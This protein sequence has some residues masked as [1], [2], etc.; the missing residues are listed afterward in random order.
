MK[1][2]LLILLF[3]LPVC[4]AFSQSM[5][6]HAKMTVRSTLKRYIKS[7]DFR[8]SAIAEHGDTMMLQVNEPSV[9]QVEFRY[10]FNDGNWC[11][12]EQKTTCCEKCLSDL[13]TDVLDSKK[14][15][16]IKVNDNTYVSKFSKKR[17]LKI[18]Q[19]NEV[20]QMNITKIKWSKEEYEQLLAA[21]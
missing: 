6:G 3:L 15:E 10:L 5:I 19:T 7:H 11:I 20:K 17:L 8:N 14:Y 16:W 21:R 2:Q 18:T 1:K 12:A 13:M 9:A 4:A